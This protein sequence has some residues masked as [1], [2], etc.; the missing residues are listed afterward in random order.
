M[1]NANRKMPPAKYVRL[2]M[3]EINGLAAKENE[4]YI[5]NKRLNAMPIKLNVAELKKS[6]ESTRLSGPFPRADLLV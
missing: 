4:A 3:L 5:A 6:R 2:W 1:I